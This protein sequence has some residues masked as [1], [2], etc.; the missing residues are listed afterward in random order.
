MSTRTRR[1]L[2]GLRGLVPLRLEA[3]LP[4][5]DFFIW[6]LEGNVFI[7]SSGE[8]QVST[9]QPHPASLLEVFI[10]SLHLL[11]ERAHEAM[12]RLQVG[13]D[14]RILDLE[15]QSQLARGRIL[16]LD[17]LIARTTDFDRAT[18]KHLGN[19]RRRGSDGLVLFLVQRPYT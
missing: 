15:H 17:D 19:G 6:D 16:L 11:L 3:V 13:L 2:E 9:R 18:R 4:F 8:N 12:A 1:N 7:W 10:G 5:I 14:L